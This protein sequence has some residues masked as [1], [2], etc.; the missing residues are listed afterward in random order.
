MHFGAQVIAAENS[1]KLCK[2][3]VCRLVTQ[4]LMFGKA[5]TD[6]VQRCLRTN[7]ASASEREEGCRVRVPLRC[8]SPVTRLIT[9]ALK[10]TS[11]S[12]FKD[13]NL[14]LSFCPSR[15]N[16]RASSLVSGL[17]SASCWTDFLCS[18]I[19]A[20]KRY[21]LEVCINK[22]ISISFPASLY[23]GEPVYQFPGL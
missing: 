21:L 20:V 8:G 3:A 11:F 7:H 14:S 13:L 18:Q 10:S 9:Q 6:S 22:I 17:K 15:K 1:Y 2:K 5:L 19:S 12:F 23:S 16:W 4:H